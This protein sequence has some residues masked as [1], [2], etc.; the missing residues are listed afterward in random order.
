[1]SVFTESTALGGPLLRGM[2]TRK[3]DL[4]EQFQESIVRAIAATAGCNVS[5]TSID[6]GT[7]LQLEHELQGEE[8]AMLKLQLKAVTSGWNMGRTRI[9]AKMP[10]E[11]FERMSRPSPLFNSIV[12]IMDLPS[13]PE[14]WLEVSHPYTYAKH[15]CYWVNLAGAP[16]PQGVG[17]KVTVSAPASNVFDD[18]SLCVMMDKIRAGG[19][20]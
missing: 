2:P 11:R 19:A 6:N 17:N 16:T 9:S 18:Q 10:R 3:T 14:E 7:D 4:M 5:S 1:M 8:D 13:N 12:V 20:P 15:C